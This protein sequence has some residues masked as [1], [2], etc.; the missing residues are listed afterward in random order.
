MSWTSLV[1]LLGSEW[2]YLAG[3]GLIGLAPGMEG[4]L[5]AWEAHAFGYLAGLLLVGP[6]TRL[7]GARPQ[8][9]DSSADLGDASS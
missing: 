6:W 2:P 5:I 8:P 3:A 4:A 9:F 7:W 1:Y